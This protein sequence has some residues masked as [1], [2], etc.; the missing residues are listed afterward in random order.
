[1]YIYIYIYTHSKS[2]IIKMAAPEAQLHDGGD[3]VVVQEVAPVLLDDPLR[4]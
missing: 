3:E 2:N 1:M 4:V